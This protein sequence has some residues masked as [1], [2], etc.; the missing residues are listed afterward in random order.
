M[1]KSLNLRKC[2]RYTFLFAVSAACE[3]WG[4]FRDFQ[5]FSVCSLFCSQ[6]LIQSQICADFGLQIQLKNVY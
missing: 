6:P 4:G 1:K 5:A 3:M 2:C